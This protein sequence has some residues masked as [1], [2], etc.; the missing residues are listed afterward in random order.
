[1]GQVSFDVDNVSA[2]LNEQFQPMVV[3]KFVT[4]VSN[5]HNSNAYTALNGYGRC[6][7]S[8]FI[9]TIESRIAKIDDE[10]RNLEKYVISSIDN[11]RGLENRLLER[12]GS[13]QVD[14][15]A[16]TSCLTSVVEISKFTRDYRSDDSM[17]FLEYKPK[18]TSFSSSSIVSGQANK[19]VIYG[20]SIS[21]YATNNDSGYNV[22]SVYKPK[23]EVVVDNEENYS[24]SI[25]DY[26]DNFL[27][28]TSNSVINFDISSNYSQG[29]STNE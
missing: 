16:L 28:T 15:D 20:N 27:T 2:N 25:S 26:F 18:Y 13:V 5:F 24:V 8:S 6:G 9:S 7:I 23:E 22:S 19:Q 11:Y 21:K 14:S 4:E 1:M 29:E 3:N 17:A 10:L 12:G